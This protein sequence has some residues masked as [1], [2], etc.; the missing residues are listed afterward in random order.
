MKIK[1]DQLCTMD[2]VKANL[3]DA[4]YGYTAADNRVYARHVSF[5]LSVLADEVKKSAEP[6]IESIDSLRENL[7]QSRQ[8]LELIAAERDL[9]EARLES[10]I[11]V[12]KLLVVQIE[13]LRTKVSDL[14]AHLDALQPPLAQLDPF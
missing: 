1:F 4:M 11:K 3:R 13:Q 7:E 14:E 5:L 12:N 10:A 2:E 9:S 8:S 6:G